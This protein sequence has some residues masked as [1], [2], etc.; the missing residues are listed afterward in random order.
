[1]V[2]FIKVKQI[3][4][5]GTTANALVEL[6]D[7]SRIVFYNDG[8]GQFLFR[9]AN[10]IGKNLENDWLTFSCPVEK[11]NEILAILEKLGLLHTLS[12]TKKEED[13]K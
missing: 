11:R 2:G 12:D 6:S 10:V 7:V 8:E 3:F 13:G 1:M 5:D 9:P 4:A